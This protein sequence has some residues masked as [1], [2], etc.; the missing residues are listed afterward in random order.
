M[1]RTHTCG[2][3]TEK[4][5]GRKTVLCGWVHRRRDHGGLIFID[6]RDREGLT[7]VV[8]GPEKKE[9]FSQAQTLRPEF[10]VGL[11]GE[12]RRRPAG[13]ENKRLSTGQI[14]VAADSLA[15]LNPSNTPPFEIEEEAVK[16]DVKLS[17]EL[18]L[19]YRYLDLRRPQMFQNLRLRHRVCQI[20]RRF[21]DTRGFIEIETPILT[22]STPE[23]ARDYLVPSRLNPGK[24]YA[25]PQSP[26][27]FKQL[28]MVAGFERYFQIS[29]CFRDEDLRAD[30]QPEF[31]QID[32][33]MSF[34]DEEDILKLATEM[35]HEIFKELKPDIE[36]RLKNKIDFQFKPNLTYRESADR[37]GADSPD[38]RFA[39]ELV[40][41]SDFLRNSEFKTFRTVLESGGIV[42]GINSGSWGMTPKQFEELTEFVKHSGAKGLVSFTKETSGLAS[43]VAKFFKEEELKAVV[44]AMRAK[45]GDTLLLVADKK[46]LAQKVLGLLRDEIGRRRPELTPDSKFH[47]C[48]VTGFP[49]FEWSEEE[50]NWTSSHHPFTSPFPEDLPLLE[51]E[52]K[53][54]EVRARAYDLVLNGHEI[55]SG[56]IRIH[57]RDVQEKIFTVLGIPE[58]EQKER[59]G[60][61]LEA[62]SYG[63]PP[64]GGIALGLDRLVALLT[65][66]DS[67]RDVIAFPKTQKAFCPMTEA[68]SDVSQK[69]LKELG[70]TIQGGKR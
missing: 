48:W 59:F 39:M 17:E 65:A 55:A 44:K 20:V 6:L 56:S 36:E 60:F 12:V 28:L 2:E 18:R 61:L 16:K 34:V 32:I 29:R 68:P 23:G 27:L 62:F 41:L 4:E 35:V 31:T 69:Q 66:S 45:E 63:A 51:V 52:A 47:F 67:I 26:Q 7:Q 13:M 11:S 70:I 1:K 40:D 24:F 53:R 46:P 9:L 30:R 22:K 50:K 5:I 8:F 54:G 37:F 15:V 42:A 19:T 38:L 33:E 3:L 43:P 58:Q 14:E 10:V 21:L 25:L 57:Q 64:H 49:L